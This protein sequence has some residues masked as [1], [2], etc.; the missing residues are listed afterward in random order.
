MISSEGHC[1]LGLSSLR[2]ALG[3]GGHRAEALLTQGIRNEVGLLD[4]L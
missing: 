2:E 4:S 3:L 1:A